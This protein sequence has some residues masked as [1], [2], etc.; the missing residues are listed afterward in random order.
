MSIEKLKSLEEEK[1]EKVYYKVDGFRCPRC[2]DYVSLWKE[3]F[4]PWLFKCNSEKCD[5]EA[6]FDEW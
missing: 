2:C 6:P 3:S 1:E 5:Y 4:G